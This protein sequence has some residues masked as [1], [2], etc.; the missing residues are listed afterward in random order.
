MK[1]NN[2]VLRYNLIFLI[3]LLIIVQ[4]NFQVNSV[5]SQ[6][7]SLLNQKNISTMNIKSDDK[8]ITSLFNPS[9]TNNPNLTRIIYDIYFT[10]HTNGKDVSISSHFTYQ[11]VGEDDVNYIIHLIDLTTILVES[12]ISTINV[13]DA[14]GILEYKWNINGN[15]NLVNVTLLNPIQENEYYSFTIDYLLEKAIIQNSDIVQSS[16]LQWA[17]THD[18]NIEQF[19][20][21][22]TLPVKYT[23]FNQ[24]A[25]DP[26]PDY[27]SADG[28]RLEWHFYNII[29]DLTQSWII[30]FSIYETSNVPIDPIGKGFWLG[31]VATFIIGIILGGLAVF[32]ILKSRTDT[33]RK[34]I[35]ETLLSS[36]EKEILRIIKNQNGVTTQSKITSES[37]FSKAKVSYYLT[38]LENKEIISRERW[39]R[40]NRIR[41]ID[42]SVDKVYFSSEDKEKKNE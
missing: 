3:L 21:I 33:E 29:N 11:N 42:G 2:F 26:E 27:K 25:L 24:S 8:K 7:E 15:V 32:F 39:G 4:I 22:L 5:G 16:I 19:S 41:I 10:I 28:R 34:E 20:L 37:G 14:F 40:M 35:V 18:E 6:N 31:L 23:L 9:Q 36:P 17:I 1:R 30:R 38:E 13:Y 12:R